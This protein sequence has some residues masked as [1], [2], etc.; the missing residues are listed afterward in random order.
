VLDLE[1]GNVAFQTP[2][3]FREEA[4]EPRLQKF[5]GAF[6]AEN[7]SNHLD[8]MPRLQSERAQPDSTT[9]NK[10]KYKDVS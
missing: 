10:R 6:L 4:T 1:M 8:L 3:R 9:N 2:A 5:F 7:G